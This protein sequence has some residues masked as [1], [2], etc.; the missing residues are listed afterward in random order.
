MPARWTRLRGIARVDRD[1]LASTPALFVLQHAAKRAPALI[2]NRLVQPR[3]RRDMASRFVSRAF[4]RPRHVLDL[5]IFKHDDY[6]VFAGLGTEFV[7]EIVTAIGDADI[8]LGK[9]LLLLL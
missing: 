4:C 5:Q 1:H 3:L 6:V 2:Q 7:Q 9:A 8:E